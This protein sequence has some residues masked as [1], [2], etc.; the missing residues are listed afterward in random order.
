MVMNRNQHSSETRAKQASNEVYSNPNK[1][2][3]ATPYD[4]STKHLTPYGG[5]LP[6][7]TMR[8]RKSD[9]KSC[10][11]IDG[12]DED[13]KGHVLVPVHSGNGP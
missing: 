13:Y 5:L 3:A 9:F 8:L 2:G 12:S 6:I 4:F 11:R 1:I 7:A 10:E